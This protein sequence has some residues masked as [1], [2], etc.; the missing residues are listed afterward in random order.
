[1]WRIKALADPAR[2]A[3]ARRAAEPRPRGAP[4]QPEVGAADRGGGRHLRR[5]R[6]LRAGVPEPRTSRRRRGSASCCAARW[7]ASRR[8]RRCC[9]RCSSEYEYDALE[10]CAGGRHVHARLPARD[11]HRQAREGAARAA[12]TGR[13]RSASRSRRRGA[14]PRWS[15]PRAPGC[16]RP[17]RGA[18]RGA[19]ARRVRSARVSARAGAG[20]AG[21]HAAPGAARCRRRARE[22]AAAVYL[23]ACI[24]RIFGHA[25]GAERASACR[26]AGR[27]VA[28]APGARSGSRPTR[29][30]H[31]CATP[32]SSKGY[33]GG[34]EHMAAQ[35]VEALWRWTGDG[36]PARS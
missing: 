36:Q 22:G 35:T 10:T 25:R 9:A 12:S 17:R 31:C 26:G 4:A 14:G 28:S 13:A 1:M 11:R 32:W 24:N 23:P 7:R 33:R 21:G 18:P 5:V 34:H 19:P 27:G 30:G 6:V 29:P 20:L 8:A 15:A 2:R 3:C 16:A